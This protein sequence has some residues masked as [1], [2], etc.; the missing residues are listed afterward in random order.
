[1][2]KKK[3][4]NHILTNGP[5]ISEAKSKVNEIRQL[6]NDIKKISSDEVIIRKALDI[7]KLL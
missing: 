6:A 5:K 3:L 4:A 2:K 7:L 1:M